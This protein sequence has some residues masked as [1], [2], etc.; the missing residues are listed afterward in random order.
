MKLYVVIS[1]KPV[2]WRQYAGTYDD[3]HEAAEETESGKAFLI[4][5]DEGKAALIGALNGYPFMNAKVEKAW[6]IKN[7][8]W[9][10][11]SVDV[12]KP[13]TG[14]ILGKATKEGL[15]AKETS[16]L[17]RHNS[18]PFCGEPNPTSRSNC[19]AC[20]SDLDEVET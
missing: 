9:T 3:A 13:P 14:K 10:E 19:W 17:T 15:L 4:E 16:G 1:G 2:V 20:D 11:R 5:M 7:G 6:A 12:L 18:C 8:R